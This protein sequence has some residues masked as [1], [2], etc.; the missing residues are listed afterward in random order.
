MSRAS[1]TASPV[2]NAT[3]PTPIAHQPTVVALFEASSQDDPASVTD[4]QA[5]ADSAVSPT[6]PLNVPRV[7]DDPMRLEPAAS[8]G[9][10]PGGAAKHLRQGESNVGH[11]QESAK[12]TLEDVQEIAMMRAQ[13]V[14]YQ[15]AV[16]IANSQEETPPF[17][18]QAPKRR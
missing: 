5:Q 16:D 12:M 3:R 18:H 1:E 17:R 11:V 9:P 7:R 14:V 2:R 6:Q 10:A 4:H 15:D 13:E 8:A